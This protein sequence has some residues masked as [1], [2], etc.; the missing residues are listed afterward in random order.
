MMSVWRLVL[1]SLWHHRRVNLAVL[2]GVVVGTAVLTGALLVGDSVR[3]SLRQMTVERL[4]RTEFALVGQ[5]F[6]RAELADELSAALHKI[7]PDAPL[8]VAP[9]LLIDGTL[10]GVDGARRA[11]HVT[12]VGSD[13]RFWQLAVPHDGAASGPLIVPAAGRV[14]LN[15][16]LARELGAEIGD[17]VI[18]RVGQVSDIP[19]DSPLGRKT[20]TIRNRRLVV[21]AV[22]PARGL[23]RFALT[24]SQREPLNAFVAA[25]TL[26]NMLE[27]PGKVNAMLAAGDD[28]WDAAA[29]SAALPVTLADLGVLIETVEQDQ[30]RY[31][32]VTQ[33]RMLLDRAVADVVIKQAADL[34]VQPALTYLANSIS[35][36]DKEI[37]YSTVTA[38]DIQAEPPLGP[39]LDERGT[40]I[41]ALAE[42]EIVLNAWAT[43]QLAAKP[44][45]TVRLTFFEPES[46]HGQVRERSAE[47]RLAHIVQLAG[48]AADMRL[49]P[50]LKGVTDQTSM[51]DW[52]PP[53]PF[54]ASRIR[55]VDEDYWDEHRATPKAFISLATGRSLWGSRFGNT[56][57]LRIACPHEKTAQVTQQLTDHLRAAHEQLGFRLLPVRQRQ[58]DAA[59]GTTPFDLLFLGFSM[60]LIASALMLVS[61][62]FRLGIDGRAAQAGLMTAVGLSPSLVR[63]TLIREG[64]LVA[65]LGSV[66]GAAA[67]VGYAWLMM[68]ALRTWWVA[69]VQT[70]RLE[71]HVTPQSLLL[72]G[73]LGAL[74]AGA[75]MALALRQLN[76]LSPRQ[77]LA[78]QTE[79]L[80]PAIAKRRP[81]LALA[82]SVGALGLA[83]FAVTQREMSQIGAF[84]GAGALTLMACL[85]GVRH[86]LLGQGQRDGSAVRFSLTS[87]ATQN[88]ARH[89]GRS[90]LTIGLVAAAS[91]L[92]TALGA[93]RQ[94][95]AA[96]LPR[97]ENGTGGFALVAELD[98]P[99]YHDLNSS[100]GQA[101]LGLAQKDRD[102]LAHARI[103]PV[104]M[105]PGDDAS[106][107]N[108]YQPQNPRVIGL[109]TSLL[110][111]GGFAWAGS[112][113]A[114]D[115]QRRQ[116][117]LLLNDK[118]S[119]GR[120]IPVVVDANTAQYSLHLGG[121]GAEYHLA[122]PALADVTFAV[123]G[124]L[125]NSV[126]QGDLM[127][128]E[129]AFRKLFP[130]VSGY[131]MLLVDA[132]PE[133]TADVQAALERALSDF[134][135][136]AQ[137]TGER[138]AG[139][140]A[141][142]NTYLSTFQSL[143]GLGLLL[144]TLGL[145][146]VQ[147]RN[148][149]ERRGELALLRAA[150][151]TPRRL[152]RLVLTEHALLLVGGLA[153]GTF[154]AAWVLLP[155]LLLG[156]AGL[157]WRTLAGTLTAVLVTG[158]A[159]GALAAMSAVRAPLLAALRGQ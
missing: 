64:A 52:D 138:L 22:V 78:G 36:G 99:L 19:A 90:T 77:L 125:A 33:Q 16:P 79:I 159:V 133:D 148:V 84:F 135:C 100:A 6:F 110:E 48:P 54:Q 86:W 154:S 117:W 142:Q 91:F 103:Y 116:P 67:G 141:V 147:L 108:L 9:L 158:L 89:A 93:F 69:A 76:R 8:H 61:L 50:E 65:L 13:E 27:Q 82:G 75:A 115:E 63:R 111:R 130:E 43:E 80:A 12:V 37:P 55:K 120:A 29:V 143:G 149:V 129:E 137:P 105:R 20:E 114:T 81:W 7:R 95:P 155:H 60:F 38:L 5:R 3:G 150:G 140:L 119:D 124:L 146:A 157:P 88:A 101:E 96:A 112:A 97:K 71:L 1:R 42:N 153:V 44:G 68:L 131:R 41:P 73:G 40:A 106:C 102:A 107:L 134:G 35:T 104:R 25:E 118:P 151:F 126:L 30:R 123:A 70:S 4:G 53:F 122:D 58:L 47:F 145:A 113:A 21:A 57:S 136:D 24:P 85:A 39:F 66:L 49:T 23:G 45:D 2:W 26:Q 127:I 17:E 156:A 46:T 92:V 28:A 51:A 121:V 132:P 31:L 62:L 83:A 152:M 87:L 139:F 98:L 14:I 11:S 144:G 109:P 18:L 59:R 72:G 34:V 32:D 15:E 74:A 128:G 10:V 94:D 56:T